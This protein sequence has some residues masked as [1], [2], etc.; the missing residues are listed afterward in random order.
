VTLIERVADTWYGGVRVDGA[1]GYRATALVP[2]VDEAVDGALTENRLR[3]AGTDIPADV[4]T[5]YTDLQPGTA[6]DDVKALLATI[7]DA[8]KPRNAYDTARAIESYL[9]NGDNFSY[10]PNVSDIDCG[11]RGIADCFVVSRR[12]YCEHYATT[13]VVMLRLA[14]IP[15]RFVEGYLPGDRDGGGEETIRKS[16]AHAWV[17]A[18]FPGIGWVEFDPTGGGVGEPSELPAGPPVAS[19]TPL[20]S[21]AAGTPR[22]TGNDRRDEPAGPAGGTSVPPRTPG[23]GPIIVVLIPTVGLLVVLGAV[24]LRRRL[25]RPVQPE[26]VYRTVARMAGRLGHPRRPT[27]TVYEYMGSLSEAVPSAG[28]ELELVARSTV[29]TTYGRRR[30]PPDR[31]AALGEAQ[32]RLRVALLRLLFHRG[33]RTR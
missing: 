13:M 18:W 27:Q 9:R 23:V 26:V 17:E 22:P 11:G 15:A 32:R 8:A 19:P 6:G 25:G 29:E 14:D 4:R 5:A 7:L 24:W 28:P 21:G 16:Q 20:P 33:G 2:V 10:D 31:L 3:A 30:L 12:G 1:G